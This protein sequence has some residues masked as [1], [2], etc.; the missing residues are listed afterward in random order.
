MNVSNKVRMRLYGRS[1]EA[2]TVTWRNLDTKGIN[3][4][5]CSQS[6]EYEKG[7]CV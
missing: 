6:D 2:V 5:C 3:N 4:L 1:S 7:W